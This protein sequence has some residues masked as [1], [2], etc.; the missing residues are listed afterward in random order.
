MWYFNFF[1]GYRK[2]ILKYEKLE[3]KFYLW[4]CKVIYGCQIIR[5]FDFFINISS[6]IDQKQKDKL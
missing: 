5:Q 3:L 6:I 1:I 2:N 4:Y